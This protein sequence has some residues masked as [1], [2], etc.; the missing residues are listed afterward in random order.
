M[1]HNW[2]HE[3]WL[4]RRYD[5]ILKGFVHCGVFS[6]ECLILPEHFSS[7]CLFLSIS[8]AIQVVAIVV[9]WHKQKSRLCL[10]LLDCHC[11][12]KVSVPAS[13]EV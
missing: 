2:G 8:Y 12:C 3:D 1:V 7:E 9:R 10:V 13:S 6:K 5:M 4:H 11:K